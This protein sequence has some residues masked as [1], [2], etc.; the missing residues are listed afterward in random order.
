LPIATN[1]VLKTIQS[2]KEE[3][4]MVEVRTFF[5]QVNN[6]VYISLNREMGD[7][8]TN[9]LITKA[10]TISLH[11]I[12]FLVKKFDKQEEI[13]ID[14]PIDLRGVYLIKI[15]DS[16]DKIYIKKLIIKDPF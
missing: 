2:K 15:T 13:R 7:E 16:E 14:L 10:E 3:I 11:G 4:E 12:T 6:L 9:K 1:S 5:N 8:F